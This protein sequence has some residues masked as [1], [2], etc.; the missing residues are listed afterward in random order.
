[1]AGACRVGISGWTYAAWRGDFYPVGL[2]HRDELRFAAER[3]TTL[4]VNGTFYGTQRPATFQRWHEET[5]HQFVFAIKGP[6]LVTHLKR[7]R[8]AEGPLA[9]F[10]ASGVLLL[11]GKLGPLLW[12]LP[13]TLAFDGELLDAFLHL[14]PGTLAEAVE[15]AR[16]HDDRL[17]RPA[18]PDRVPALPLRHALEPRHQSYA[19]P[20]CGEICEARGVALVAADA[21]GRYP[22][23]G[24]PAR[25]LAYVRLHGE[26]QLYAGGYSDAALDRWATAMRAWA[27]QGRDVYAYFDN[28][29]DG[30]A[31]FDALR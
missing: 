14:L 31:P 24:R 15:L 27:D 5:P 29:A 6:R 12:Q 8:D 3:F 4:E 20:A 9:N 22:A 30:R 17:A 23:L 18:I 1:M 25:D 13:P 21:A 26:Q 28:D 7:L 2:R 19:D 11:G 10:L 16:G